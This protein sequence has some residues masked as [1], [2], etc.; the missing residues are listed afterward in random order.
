MIKKLMSGL[1]L[2]DFDVGPVA[3]FD[4]VASVSVSGFSVGA[5]T[6]QMTI[7]LDATSTII[8]TNET[9]NSQTKS[10]TVP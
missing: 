7:V 9:N 5:G 3:K 10:I 6:H 2:K 4:G 8:E 1:I